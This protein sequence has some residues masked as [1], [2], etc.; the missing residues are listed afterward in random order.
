MQ[1]LLTVKMSIGCL[2][3]GL[4]ALCSRWSCSGLEEWMVAHCLQILDGEVE[5]HRVLMIQETDRAL[6]L[7]LVVNEAN[8]NQRRV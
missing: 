7:F 1:D 6:L 2:S 5:E 3:S 4:E 8:L